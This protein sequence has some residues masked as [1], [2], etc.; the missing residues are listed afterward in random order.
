M[1]FVP[2]VSLDLLPGFPD[3]YV[4]NCFSDDRF[5]MCYLRRE[6]DV[7]FLSPIFIFE[8]TCMKPLLLPR[9]SEYTLSFADCCF[10]P[11]GVTCEL[12]ELYDGKKISRAKACEMFPRLHIW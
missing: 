11:V 8:G 3:V 9:K 6:D 10:H 5:H 1:F 12:D 4:P 7:A 2:R